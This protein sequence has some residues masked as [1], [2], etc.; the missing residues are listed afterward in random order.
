MQVERDPS[1]P[2]QAGVKPNGTVREYFMAADEVVWDYVP[3]NGTLCDGSGLPQP[4]SAEQAAA[5]QPS[6]FTKALYRRYTDASFSQ[7]AE[8]SPG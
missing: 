6:R 1:L 5:A 4:F 3:K 2:L 7:L 8:P